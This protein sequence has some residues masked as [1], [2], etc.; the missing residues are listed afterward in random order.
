M[1][2]TKRI[3]MKKITLAILLICIW[4]IFLLTMQ[5]ENFTF[6]LR[7]ANLDYLQA[8]RLNLATFNHQYHFGLNT[9]LNVLL[10]FAVLLYYFS[11]ERETRLLRFLISLVFISKTI[12]IISSI[13][14]MLFGDF[15]KGAYSIFSSFLFIAVEIGFVYSAYWLLQYLGSK[16]EMEVSTPFDPEFTPP[17]LVNATGGQ[18]FL[19]LFVDCTVV[20][21][22]ISPLI[23]VI[24]FQPSIRNG[25]NNMAELI[26]PQVL[27][28][29]L[30]ALV[31][32]A[33]Y[34]L[35]E[36]FFQASPGKFL[37]ETKVVQDDG[38]QLQTRSSIARTL[39]RHVPFDA[40]SFVFA[41]SGWHDAWSK[42][43]VVKERRTGVRGSFYFLI[44]PLL[45]VVFILGYL[46]KEYYHIYAYKKHLRADFEVKA[47]EN[48]MKINHIGG[49]EIIE[50]YSSDNYNTI[51]Y[52]KPEKINANKILFSVITLNNSYEYSPEV[53][54]IEDFY[55]RNREIWQKVELDR[56][57]LVYAIGE[58]DEH[59][60]NDHKAKLT[61]GKGLNVPGIDGQFIIKTINTYFQPDI[62]LESVR[63]LTTKRVSFELVNTAWDAKVIAIKTL[64]G[65]MVWTDPLPKKITRKKSYLNTLTAESPEAIEDFAF[66]VTVIDSL[67]RRFLFNFSGNVLDNKR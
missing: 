28:L 52:L 20:L 48:K 11:K 55:I 17:T 38:G 62:K 47:G 59:S 14:N 22:T 8:F 37:T 18:R 4:G 58:F 60:Y 51:I 7:S 10:I 35:F 29:L 25:L 53:E 6:W 54:T 13:L 31:R 16:K 64:K 49:N 63:S 67:N 61:D 36:Y 24:T 1:V 34:L 15:P 45:F 56:S 42:T 33:Y 43:S 12:W 41:H 65:G 9:L 21:L 19:H 40:L 3:T 27:I 5:G 30:F 46:G 26:G 44:L 39:Y 57:I 23:E 50:L 32:S 2:G 66:N